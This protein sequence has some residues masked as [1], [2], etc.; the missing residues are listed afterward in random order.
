MNEMIKSIRSHAH[1]L[2][3]PSRR[4]DRASWAK[5]ARFLN[6]FLTLGFLALALFLF[7]APY[8]ADYKFVSI[9]GGSMSPTLSAGSIAFV[10]PIASSKINTDDIIAYHAPSGRSTIVT[11]RVVEVINEGEYLSF[12]TAGDGNDNSDKNPVPSENVVGKVTFHIP[13][14][15]F[16]FNFVRQPIGYC[17]LIGLPALVIISIEMKR[18]VSQI[19]SLKASTRHKAL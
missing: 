14:V 8:L 3:K 13:Y 11:H 17:L 12:Q 9:M 2:L 4:G 7:L 18:I 16:V 5:I 1:S 19:S 15:G 6:Y 10:Q